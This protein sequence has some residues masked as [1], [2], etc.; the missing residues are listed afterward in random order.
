MHGL[1]RRYKTEKEIEFRDRSA[2][3]R[4]SLEEESLDAEES[5]RERDNYEYLQR[6]R[7][8]LH[9]MRTWPFSVGSSVKY[10]VVVA[11]NVI[12]TVM[13]V[14]GDCIKHLISPGQS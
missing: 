3:I 8:E 2:E 13:T 10:G 6:L 1:L 12:A 11:G 7:A 14:W 4:Q 9:D 5:R